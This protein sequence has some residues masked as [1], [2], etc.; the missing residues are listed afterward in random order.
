MALLS[1]DPGSTSRRFIYSAA[2]WLGISMLVG[3]LAAFQLAQPDYLRSVLPESLFSYS[4]FGRLRPVHV[5]LVLFGWL[6][7]IYF[8]AMH[9]IIPRLC[10]TTLFSEKLG[11]VTVI[12]WNF[13][14]ALDFLTLISGMTQAREYGEEIW[15]MDLLVLISA[16]VVGVNVYGTIAKRTIKSMYVSLWYFT[17]SL[18]WL[19]TL[20]IVGNKIWDPSGAFNGVTDPIVNWWYGHNVIGMWFTTVGVGIAYY[21]IPLVAGRPLYSHKL[22]LVG[23]WAIST[24][25]PQTGAH[26]LVWGPVPSW[27]VSVAA[28]SSILMII[29]VWTVLANFY[30]TIEGRWSR[31]LGTIPGRF[32]LMGGIFYFITCLQGPSQALRTFSALVHF[33]HWVVGHAHLA[34]LGA[35]SNISWGFIY[36]ALPRLLG[37]SGMHSQ[38]MASWHFWLTTVG[39]TIMAFDLWFAGLVQGSMWI[40]GSPFVQSVAAMKPYMWTRALAGVMIFTGQL[41][42]FYNLYMTATRREH[43]AERPA[44]ATAS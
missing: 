11:N 36:Y 42:F 18:I 13:V 14:M 17:G 29:P 20:Y 32:L 37:R 10:G 4:T 5:H 15:P 26:H 2:F 27:L 41:F 34:M 7:T 33:T 6:T 30:K 19:A 12:V 38:T 43:A 3:I 22:S 28:V 31:F 40:A 44:A 16:A 21:L 39:F 23:F 24:I 25:Y 9:Y 8:G 35:F 1:A